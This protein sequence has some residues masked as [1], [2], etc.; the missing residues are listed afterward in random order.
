MSLI[1]QTG[2]TEGSGRVTITLLGKDQAKVGHRF[3][4]NGPIQGCKE[5]QIKNICFNLE[6]GRRYRVI[7]VRDKE[8]TCPTFDSGVLV[9][10]VEQVPFAVGVPRSMI[11]E[12]SVITHHPVGCG[13]RGCENWFL[14][15]PPAVEEGTRLKVL[16]LIGERKCR[17]GTV[18]MEALADFAGD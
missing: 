4:Y 5:C 3:I 7:T 2:D 14:T 6:K 18:L 17:D 1:N 16:K 10:E 11:V 12:G 9:V 15:H 13:I 8:H